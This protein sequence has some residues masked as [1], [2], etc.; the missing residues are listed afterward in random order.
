MGSEF[1]VTS[2]LLSE[3]IFERHA[4]D[5]NPEPLELLAQGARQLG[6]EIQVHAQDMFLTNWP[7]ETFDVVFSNGVL[8]HYEFSERIA[9]LKECARIT[10][11]G[12]LV[13]VGVPNHCSF[14]YRFSYLLRRL[15]G[16][17]HFPPE[18]KIATFGQELAVLAS[19]KA[20]RM[21]LFDQESVFGL[22][23]RARI[24]ALPFRIWHRFWKFEPYLRVFEMLRI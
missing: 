20:Q 19:L 4:L 11:K 7:D 12:G 18:K 16:K 17:W 13:I 8:E 24:T 21:M 14:P 9:A 3:K 2:L 23:P 5:L 15:V 10:R 1:G 22:L 6:Q